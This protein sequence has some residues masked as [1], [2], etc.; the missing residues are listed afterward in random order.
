MPWRLGRGLPVWVPVAAAVGLA[1]VFLAGFWLTPGERGS[2]PPSAITPGPDSSNGTAPGR[3][4]ATSATELIVLPDRM[5]GAAVDSEPHG[6][7]PGPGTA[8][9]LQLPPLFMGEH[10]RVVARVIGHD[11]KVVWESVVDARTTAAP[12]QPAPPAGGWSPGNYRLEIIPGAGA[13]TSAT[14]V[15][16][17]RLVKLR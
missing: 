4:A 3:P 15:F 2:L 17:F 10:E 8:L 6:S 14:R 5:R 12:L 9:M 7:V 16:A 11:G 13:D 1:A